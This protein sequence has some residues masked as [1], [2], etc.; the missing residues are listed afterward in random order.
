MRLP[1]DKDF[2]AGRQSL[3]AWLL[4]NAS[5]NTMVAACPFFAGCQDAL[6]TPR[7]FL[8][9]GSPNQHCRFQT[10]IGMTNRNA[11]AKA[12]TAKK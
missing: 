4:P 8:A 6:R 10:G 2:G 1:S 9:G 12:A 5:W 7:H 3:I 11:H